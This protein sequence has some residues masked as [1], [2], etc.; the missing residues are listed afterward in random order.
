VWLAQPS[1]TVDNV[2]EAANQI[3][4]NCKSKLLTQ[5]QVPFGPQAQ[6]RGA[7]PSM[8]ARAGKV[9]GRQPSETSGR[10]QSWKPCWAASTGKAATRATVPRGAKTRPP[11]RSLPWRLCS[12]ATCVCVSTPLCLSV[13]SEF[14]LAWQKHAPH[15]QLCF[16][17]FLDSRSHLGSQ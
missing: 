11:P 3:S 5:D 7:R 2:G 8:E 1:A 10:A 16:G 13:V 15:L 9:G 14:L 6:G 4:P 12:R 17:G